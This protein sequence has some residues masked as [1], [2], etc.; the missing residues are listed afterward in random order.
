MPL[1]IAFVALVLATS[2]AAQTPADTLDFSETA[3]EIIGGLAAMQARIAYPAAD[4]DAGRQGTVIIRFVVTATGESAAVEVARSASP[5]LDAVAVAAVRQTRFVPGRQDGRPV[6]V[7]M[8]VPIRFTIRPDAPAPDRSHLDSGALL[9]GLGQPWPIAGLA[10]PDSV[11]TFDGARSL[12]MWGA[13]QPGVEQVS[14]GVTAD[15]L[16]FVVLRFSPEAVPQLRDLAR[17]IADAHVEGK[18]DGFVLARDLAN[19]GIP[20]AA[21]LS[22]DPERRLLTYRQPVCRDVPGIGCVA[23]FPTLVDGLEALV[24]RVRYPREALTFHTSG[25]VLVAF[26]VQPDGSL[27]DVRVVSNTAGTGIGARALET[28]ALRVVRSARYLPA[29]RGT[30]PVAT[31][32][33]IPILFRIG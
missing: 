19:G 1:R 2:A 24:G 8:T 7:R 16:R 29:V 9:N 22:V 6:N 20:A 13:S 14:A 31:P 26:V 4:L 27:T 21:D 23:A 10:A 32:A 30:R 15:T 25:T 12:S 5:G 3:P 18:P 17:Q 28:E 11:Q 33:S